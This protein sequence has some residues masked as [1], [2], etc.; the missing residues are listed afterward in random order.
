MEKYLIDSL[1][2]PETEKSEGKEEVIKVTFEVSEKGIAQ[3]PTMISL[4]GG[5]T[6]FD[7][8]VKRLIQNMPKWEPDVNKK[9][10][11]VASME[12]AIVQFRLPDSLLKPLPNNDDSVL[13]S[14]A[15]E[16]PQMQGGESSF[17]TYL[18]WMIR[19]PQLELEQGK[20]GVVYIYFEVTNTGNITNVRC[21][22]G[23]PGA[24][25]LAKEAIRVI[26]D[27]PRWIPGK[28][29]GKPVRVGMTVPI[30]FTLK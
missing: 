21:L 2:Y 17:Q 8:E 11:P 15:E 25:G 10:N 29:K 12:S 23:V 5:S 22:K 13:Y 16:M 9:G 30:R 3:N 18:K 7:E 26:K 20:D 24:P 4:F 27:M 28:M 14:F 1:R 19:Y 6:G